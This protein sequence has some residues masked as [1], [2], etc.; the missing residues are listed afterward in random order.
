MELK[1]LLKPVYVEPIILAS[2]SKD[3][4]EKMINPHGGVPQYTDHA[5]D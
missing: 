5:R 2:Y 1:E 4:L 3:E